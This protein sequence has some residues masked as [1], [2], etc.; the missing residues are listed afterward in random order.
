MYECDVLDSN[1]I[2]VRMYCIIR[3]VV[4]IVVLIAVYEGCKD[5]VVFYGIM[6]QSI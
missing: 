1:G 4:E 6:V 2:G 5:A 3:L